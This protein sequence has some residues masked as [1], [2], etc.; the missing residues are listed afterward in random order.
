MG[1]RRATGDATGVTMIRRLREPDNGLTH[2][3]GALLSLVALGILLTLAWRAGSPRAVVAFAVFGLSLVALYTAST[4][5]HAL[6]LGPVGIAR[7]LRIDHMMIFVLIA[8]T[9]TPFCLLALHGGWRWGLLG[10][11][12]ALAAG[13]IALKV[14][15]MAAPEWLSTAVYVAMGWLAVIAAPAFLAAVPLAGLSWVLAGGIIYT[16]GAVVFATGW[17]R[18]RP[19]VF[20]AHALWH[21]LVIAGSACHVWAV[22]RYLTPLA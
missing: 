14:G 5:H 12:W 20:G 10:G 6:P 4:I 7:T 2:L 15:W 22:A 9:Y 16:V 21:L 17:P 19:G 18:L 8:G 11:V 3:V 1:Q 13:G